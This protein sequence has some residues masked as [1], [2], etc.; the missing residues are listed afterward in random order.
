MTCNKDTTDLGCL[1][2]P[3]GYDDDEAVY[4]G[5]GKCKHKYEEQERCVYVDYCGFR[6]TKIVYRCKYCKKRKVRKYW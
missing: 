2:C 5:G 1:D 6:V 4:C 3:Y